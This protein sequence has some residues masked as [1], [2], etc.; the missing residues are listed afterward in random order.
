MNTR[1]LGEVT[2]ADGRVAPAALVRSDSVSSLGP[3]GLQALV[4]YGIR[5]I[6]D[7]RG[8]DEVRLDPVRAPAGVAYRH[9]PIIDVIGPEEAALPE[10]LPQWEEAYR[11]MLSRFQTGFAAAVTAVAD[12]GPGGVLVQ[13]RLGRDRTGIVVALLLLLAGATDEAIVEDYALSRACL[14]GTFDDL[15]A[16]EPDAERKRVHEWHRAQPEDL[17]GSV[18]ADL[19]QSYG[20][21][22]GYLV[23]GGAPADIGERIAGRLLDPGPWAL[24]Q[25]ERP[26]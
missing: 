8:T 4:G 1:H 14:Q 21:V 26:V 12:A 2:V 23:A 24:S 13:C 3:S 16:T 20:G 5:T 9:A 6:I 11:E 10:P 17:I 18:V 22:E 19:R 15:I 25:S 7:L